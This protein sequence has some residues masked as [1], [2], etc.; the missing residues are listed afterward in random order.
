MSIIKPNFITERTIARNGDVDITYDC[1]CNSCKKTTEECINYE[2]FDDLKTHMKS[3]NNIDFFKC[4]VP[5]CDHTLPTYA[6]VITQH[7]KESHPKIR[8][9]MRLDENN[10][11]AIY[12]K[13]CDSYT[14]FTHFHCRECKH[15]NDKSLFFKTKDELISH[16]KEKHPKEKKNKEQESTNRR[17]K[18]DTKFILETICKF[19]TGCYNFHNGKCGF[20]HHEHDENYIFSTRAPSSICKWDAPWKGTRCNKKICPF[21]HLTGRVTY[22]LEKNKDTGPPFIDETTTTEIIVTTNDSV[23]LEINNLKQEIELL[24]NRNKSEIPDVAPETPE[25]AE[26]TETTET[27]E[28]VETPETPETSEPPETPKTPETPET[29]KTPKTPKTRETPKTPKTPKKP[30]K[31]SKGTEK[32]T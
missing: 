30:K 28:T 10:K 7:I 8:Q 19:K 15:D 1:A 13:G 2:S 26:T 9:K 20:N 6:G 14:G 4:P 12:C 24:K 18:P 17:A 11:T 16:L 3:V 32:S 22:V 27:P 25:S 29:P 5:S 23:T 31:D 21:D